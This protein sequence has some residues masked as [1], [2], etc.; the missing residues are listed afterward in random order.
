MVVAKW[1]CD[2]VVMAMTRR[3]QCSQWRG[4]SGKVRVRQADGMSVGE[5]QRKEWAHTVGSGDTYHG[6]QGHVPWE[7]GHGVGAGVHSGQ[8]E[9][10][11][12]CTGTTGNPCALTFDTWIRRCFKRQVGDP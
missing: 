12:E 8:S 4:L 7:V 9:C 10:I 3:R 6:Q 1:G 11:S 2:I 5:W